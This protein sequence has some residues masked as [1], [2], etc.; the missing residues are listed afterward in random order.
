MDDV[1]HVYR[2]NRISVD[3]T[4]F[5]QTLRQNRFYGAQLPL[6]R[7]LAPVAFGFR[8][9]V[10]NGKLLVRNKLGCVNESDT[11]DKKTHDSWGPI[12]TIHGGEQYRADRVTLGV[13]Q[14]Y[15]VRILDLTNE[16]SDRVLLD[17]QRVVS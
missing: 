12:F 9:R 7:S 14:G 10:Q 8:F 2:R 5:L 15:L 17:L 4:H 1:V 3:A 11:V 6:E 13:A 16:E